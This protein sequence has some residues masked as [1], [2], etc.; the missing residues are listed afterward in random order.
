MKKHTAAMQDCQTAYRA[1]T[2]PGPGIHIHPARVREA[3]EAR[4]QA[5]E[6]DKNFDDAVRTTRDSSIIIAITGASSSP[7]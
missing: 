4:A 3:L 2:E 1:L 5:H 7:S 6:A